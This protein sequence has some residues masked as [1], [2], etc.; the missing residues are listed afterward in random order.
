MA[1]A[2]SQP[3]DPSLLPMPGPQTSPFDSI[4]HSDERG[5]YWTARELMPLLEYATWHRFEEAIQ[6][7]MTDCAKAGRTVEENFSVSGKVSG[8]RGPQQKDYR[9]SRY[10]CRLEDRLRN[11]WSCGLR[12]FSIRLAYGRYCR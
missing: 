10:A 7:A 11:Q 5:D 6:R 9:L 4:R 12:P 1:L 2:R 3:R 8:K